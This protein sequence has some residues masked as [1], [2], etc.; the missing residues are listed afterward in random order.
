MARN[1]RSMNDENDLEVGDVVIF[2]NGI[3]PPTEI[4]IEEFHYEWSG[5]TKIKTAR[6]AGSNYDLQYLRKKGNSNAS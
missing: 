1:D 6:Y 3:H 2:D 4:I 5:G